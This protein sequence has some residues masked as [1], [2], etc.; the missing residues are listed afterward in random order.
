MNPN[1]PSC[2]ASGAIKYGRFHR[3]EDAQS[4]QRFRCKACK[5]GFSTASVPPL[6]GKNQDLARRSSAVYRPP[7]GWN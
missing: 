6:T 7:M 1:C 2:A 4:I 5:T 3:A